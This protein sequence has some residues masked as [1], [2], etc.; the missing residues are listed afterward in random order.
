MRSLENYYA[1]GTVIAYQTE[2]GYKNKTEVG[3]QLSPVITEINSGWFYNADENENVVASTTAAG[4]LV[5]QWDDPTETLFQAPLAYIVPA[6]YTTIEVTGKITYPIVRPL[7]A[8][9]ITNPTFSKKGKL[10]GGY[11]NKFNVYLNGAVIVTDNDCPSIANLPDAGRVKV[12]AVK[13]TVN[14]VINKYNGEGTADHDAIKSEN[15]LPIEVKNEAILYVTSVLGDG[16][17]GGETTFT[18]SKGTFIVSNCGERGV[19]GNVVV[20]GPSA[21]IDAS[22]IT[23][24][25]TDPTSTDYTTFDGIFIAKNNVKAPHEIGYPVAT[26]EDPDKKTTG[27]ADVFARNGKAS[28]GVFGTSN[29]ELKGVAIIGSIGAAG[30]QSAPFAIDC[31]SADRLY[32][33]QILHNGLVYINEITTVEEAYV[34]VPYEGNPIV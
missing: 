7:D 25:V 10:N 32:V 21:Q 31:G 26:T 9:E 12:I 1:E 23:S 16:V 30:T 6:E 5:W 15:N 17:D 34:A 13:E 33:N 11:D 18:D 14:A 29:A 27:Y 24:Y 2:E 20:I 22:V 3:T 4:H 19:K 8:I 28:K